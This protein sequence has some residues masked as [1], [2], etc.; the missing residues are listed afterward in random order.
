[1]TIQ[2]FDLPAR[3]RTLLIENYNEAI[4]NLQ[5]SWPDI[6]SLEISYR[7]IESFDPD[8]ALSI[9]EEP[10]ANIQAA[11]QALRLLLSELGSSKIVAFVRIIE[12]PPD[13][14]RSVRRL[15]SDDLG[16]MIS[17]DAIATKIG[18]VLPR[19]YEGVFVCA[20][21]GHLSRISQPNEQEL[22]EP[23]E[24]FQIDGGCGR[25]RNQT[26]FHQ[27]VEDSILIDTQFIE[28][29]EP[30]ENLRGGVQPERI[31]CIAEHDLAGQLNPGDRVTANGVLFVRS[32]RKSGKD[33]P[34][35]DIF[36][37]IHSIQRE[38]IPLEEIQITEDEEREIKELARREDIHDLL[39]RSIAPSIFG[40]TRQK[41]SLML[42]LFGGVASKAKDGTRLRGDI[43]ILLMG[44]PGVAKSQ[45]LSYMAQISPRGRFTSGMSAS[46][47]GLTAAAVQ[48]SA[49][50]G[51]WTLEAGALALADLGLASIDE[52]DKMNENDRSS[53]HEAMEQQRISVSKAGI[54]ATLS[55]RCAI[56][57]AANPKAGRFQSVS[58]VPFTQQI[59]L[60]PALISRFDVIWLLT[61]QPQAD[62]DSMIAN[63]IMNNRAS[64]TPEILIEKG[65]EVDPSKSAKHDG[66]DK[67]EG[68]VNRELIRKYVAFAKRSIHPKLT[69]EAQESLRDF[70][71]ETRRK[72]GESHDSIAIS[73]RA[74][75]GLY[76]LA[77]ASARV[78]LSEVATIEDAERSIRLT[79]FW[80]HELMGENFDETTLQSGK[81]A[82]T[83][84][85]E[86]SILEIVRRLFAE[87]GN[88]VNLA[89]VLTEAGRIDINRDAAEDIIE[90]LC[91]DGRLMRPGGYDTLQPV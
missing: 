69:D 67:K 65:S 64:S 20:A 75:E 17:V 26:K 37:R 16:S 32:Q 60:K 88:I 86:R 41:E 44:D 6:R 29:Q 48:D 13:S 78:R 1:M 38:N 45:L 52:F 2:E 83:R 56:L 10:D 31:L 51:R 15:R 11:E 4:H 28:L 5:V 61:D 71:V 53:M 72:G 7:E 18:K 77:Q 79:R 21:C 34:I 22:V 68:I 43:H 12:L 76:R 14:N 73:A 82:T 24:C 57:A 3:W 55:T 49:A 40:M 25:K 36:M 19:T 8:F 66:V 50:D 90:A 81:K 33:T 27:R 35:F 9:I 42:Q 54:N 62:H 58:E 85:R 80:R 84:N 47:A 30:P 39:T 23:V 74:I 63:H 46:A 59:N 91:R 89:D 87:T 70:Y